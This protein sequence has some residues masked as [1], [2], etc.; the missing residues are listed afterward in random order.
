MIE[1]K[2]NAAKIVK[3]DFFLKAID[4]VAGSAILYSEG[5]L[6]ASHHHLSLSKD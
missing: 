2:L 5:A 6:V 3:D 4:F 1:A